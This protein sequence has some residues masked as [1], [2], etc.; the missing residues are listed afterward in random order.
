MMLPP[1][2]AHL[3]VTKSTSEPLTEMLS[4]CKMQVM[5]LLLNLHPH[6]YRIPLF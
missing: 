5:T 4:A 1:E 6:R 3:I 2:R